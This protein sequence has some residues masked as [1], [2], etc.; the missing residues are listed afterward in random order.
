MPYQPIPFTAMDLSVDK[1]TEAASYGQIQSDGYWKKYFSPDGPKFIWCKRPGLTTWADTGETSDIWDIWYAV[2][3]DNIITSHWSSGEVYKIARATGAATE[4]TGTAAMNGTVRPSFA[5]APGGAYVYISS[6]GVV[7]R[8]PTASGTGAALTDADAP[9]AV[10]AVGF[11]NNTLI[12]ANASSKRFDWSQ[13]GSYTGWDGEYANT[14]TTPGY[15]QR[16]IVADNYLWFFKEDGIEV[17]RDDGTTFVRESQG[18]IAVGCR[19]EASIKFINGS[20]YF[21][22]NNL[23]I[24]RMTG[25]QWPETIS[26]PALAGYISSITDFQNCEGHHL[27]WDGK[28]FY[29]LQFWGSSSNVPCLVYDIEMGQ[30]YRWGYYNA[31]SYT[32]W[33]ISG[34]CTDQYGVW[35]AGDYDTGKVHKIS[36]TQDLSADI[37][38]RLRTDFID[39]GTPDAYKFCHE[40]TILMKRSSTSTTAKTMA[41]R[42]RDDGTQTWST[43][44][45]VAIEAASTTELKV[46][47]RRLGRYK[48]RQWE[49]LI[50]D[51][52]VA[53]LV[54]AWERFEVG[55]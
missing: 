47:L 23:D 25:F 2:R 11:L 34:I 26:N 51:A 22:D 14:E 19:N 52:G 49:F 54:G 35:Y 28:D 50:S 13:A 36:G 30:W 39:R 48:R 12:A 16:M 20:F 9:T 42:Y 5:E 38:T 7:G 1:A 55:R 15:N 29:I 53:S 18:S 6:G 44:Q 31:G 10:C 45:T 3:S 41:V 46:N 37:Y 24:R 17:W 40:L 33:P 43:A 4:I 27:K 8:Y 21:M 32:R